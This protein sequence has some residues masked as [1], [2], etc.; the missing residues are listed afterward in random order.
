MMSNEIQIQVLNF[1]FG[2]PGSPDYDSVKPFWF[3]GGPSLDREITE[4][5]KEAYKLA[6]S[7]SL[8]SLAETPEGSLALIILLDQFPRNMFRGQPQAFSSD[9]QA[10]KFAKNAISKGFDK[11]MN[12]VQKMFLYMPFQH[13]EDLKDQVASVELAKG[14]DSPGTLNYAQKHY[15][16][17]KEFGRFPHR[18][19]TLGRENTPKENTYLNSEQAESFGQ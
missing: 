1:W 17:I 2:E 19:Q 12:S 5:F 3:S 11:K 18:N 14:L 13:S 16:I 4:K 10:L 15:D 6:L 7:G 8:D 9:S